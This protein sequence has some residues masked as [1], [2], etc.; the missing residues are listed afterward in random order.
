MWDK[1]NPDSQIV[2]VE[3]IFYNNEITNKIPIKVHALKFIGEINYSR[4][5]IKNY[6]CAMFLKILKTDKNKIEEKIYIDELEYD[7]F[8]D[9]LLLYAMAKSGNP[10]AIN[11]LITFIKRNNEVFYEVIEAIA[12]NATKEQIKYLAKIAYPN[13]MAVVRRMSFKQLDDF[14][15]DTSIPRDR[16]FA[17]IETGIDKYLDM[18]VDSKD[19]EVKKQIIRFS[20]SKDLDYFINDEDEYVLL[21]VMRFQREKDIKILSE[22]SNQALA[23]IAKDII[24]GKIFLVTQEDDV[25]TYEKGKTDIYYL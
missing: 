14:L 21:E 16:K 3:G 6:N 13:F 25:K 23:S 11:N 7:E 12:E 1:M 4:Y 10:K 15:W 19:K 18:F 17:V 2:M 20:R 24:N 8:H 9:S 22:N 5:K